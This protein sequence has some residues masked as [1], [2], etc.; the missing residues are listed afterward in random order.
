MHQITVKLKKDNLTNANL[1]KNTF[2]EDFFNC[3]NL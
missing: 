1:I 3:I 2:K